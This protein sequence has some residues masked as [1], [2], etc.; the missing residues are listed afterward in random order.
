VIRLYVASILTV[1]TANVG[2]PIALGFVLIKD[3]FLYDAF[4]TR[5]KSLF[6]IDLSTFIIESDQG[7]TLPAICANS[8]DRHLACLRHLLVS[9]RRSPFAF[10]IE[11]LV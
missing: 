6:D 10:E 5:L 9:L 1:A 11:N 7:S 8:C 3:S 4:Y 2:I